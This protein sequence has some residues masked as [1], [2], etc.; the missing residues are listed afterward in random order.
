MMT[1]KKSTLAN[2]IYSTVVFFDAQDLPLT[3]LEIKSNLLKSENGSLSEIESTLQTELQDD[4]EHQ[5]GLY[6]LRGRRNLVEN[7]QSRYQV[8]LLRFIRARRMLKPLRFFPYLRAVAISGSLAIG[9][10][11]DSSDIDLFIVTKNNRIWLSRFLVSVYFQILAARRHGDKIR[12]RFCL[13]HYVTEDSVITEDRNLYTAAE[14]ASLLPVLGLPAV[15]KFWQKN[16]WIRG[17]LQDPVPDPGASF[18]F[19]FG[20]IQKPLEFVWDWTIAPALNHLL[21]VYQKN[22]IRMQD[23]ILVSDRELSFHPG[24]RGQQILQKFAKFN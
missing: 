22:R 9:N 23:Y 16:P 17:Y 3:L 19:A 7:R 18:G 5:S 10:S 12:N 2:S 6:F 1:G 24:S 8:S 13:N 15:E 14:Y 11:Q 4:V 21:G 20:V